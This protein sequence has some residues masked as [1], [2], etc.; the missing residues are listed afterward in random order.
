MRIARLF[1]GSDPDRGPFFAAER[2]R[3]D[4]A[5]ERQRVAAF[6]RAGPVV[7]FTTA[8]DVDRMDP[9]RGRVVRIG[10]RTDGFW[11][12]SQALEYYVDTYGIAPDPAFYA[13]IRDSGYRCA[14]PSEAQSRQAVDAIMNRPASG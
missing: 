7:L 4:D 12:W 1:D 11:V 13:H 10:F 9:A 2:E 8:G 5:A 6:L 14:Q 3:I